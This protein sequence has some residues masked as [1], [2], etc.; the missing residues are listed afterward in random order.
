MVPPPRTQRHRYFGVLAPNSP[1][2]CAVTALVQPAK[3]VLVPAEPANMSEGAPGVVALGHA[4]PPTPESAPPRRSPAHYLWAALIARFL[5]HCGTDRS[6]ALAEQA[7]SPTDCEFERSSITSASTQ[8]L[9]TF[10]R[11]VG[12]RCGM[13]VAMRRW[14]TG[15]KSSQTGQSIGMGQRNR[16]RTLRS[17]SASVGD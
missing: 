13:T 1:L 6:Y 17:I 4:M 10:P 7:L 5:R 2:R 12:H 14:A 16:H 3:Q 9:R 11:H 8:N 15:C